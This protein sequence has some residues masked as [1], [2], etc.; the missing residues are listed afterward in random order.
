MYLPVSVGQELGNDLSQLSW[1]RVSCEVAVVESASV[2]MQSSECLPGAGGSLPKCLA[3]MDGLTLPVDSRPQF[4]SLWTSQRAVLSV[5][6]TQ[7]PASSRADGPRESKA[8]AVV[9]YMN[10][11]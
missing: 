11:S 4:L 6:E 7:W 3:H 1:P 9:S 5:L 10:W 8:E 2:A